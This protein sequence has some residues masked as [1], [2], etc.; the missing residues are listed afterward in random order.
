MIA[1]LINKLSYG[2]NICSSIEQEFHSKYHY[3]YQL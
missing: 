2:Y 3:L 1:N